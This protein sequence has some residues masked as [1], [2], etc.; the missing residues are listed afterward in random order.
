IVGSTPHIGPAKCDTIE[1]TTRNLFSNFKGAIQV[2]KAGVA[3]TVV[4]LVLLCVS[5]A[6][7]IFYS[8]SR[9]SKEK[10][11]MKQPSLKP[12]A[13]IKASL[14]NYMDIATI[15][16][17][18]IQ[19]AVFVFST[20]PDWL[21]DSYTN[22]LA[23]IALEFPISWY[24]WVL[25]G[26]VIVWNTY[27]IVIMSGGA[28]RL[29]HVPYGGLLL[30]PAATFLPSVGTIG[31][32]PALVVLLSP[33]SCRYSLSDAVMTEWCAMACW[34][35]VDW[36]HWIMAASGFCLVIIFA[37]LNIETAHIWQELHSNKEAKWDDAF[38]TIDY[39]SKFIMVML[40]VFFQSANL[41]VYYG[42]LFIMNLSMA[43]YLIK[44]QPSNVPW[45]P[46]IRAIGAFIGAWTAMCGLIF[47]EVASGT[48]KKNA[49]AG[50]FGGWLII[51]VLG[52]AI[53]RRIHPNKFIHERKSETALARLLKL[54]NTLRQVVSRTSMLSESQLRSRQLGS[55]R[56]IFL[57]KTFWT[58]LQKYRKNNP[59]DINYTMVEIAL[60]T[61]FAGKNSI[62]PPKYLVNAECS[63]NE[64]ALLELLQL[65]FGDA[66]VRMVKNELVPMRHS[67]ASHTK[68]TAS[69]PRRHSNLKVPDGYSTAQTPP[70]RSDAGMKV[71]RSVLFADGPAVEIV[72]SDENI[73]E[74]AVE[75]QIDDADSAA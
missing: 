55:Q 9:F 66:I 31:Y 27:A 71:A 32:V 75:S 5:L 38:Y 24:F 67:V 8:W 11:K 36:M 19:L 2:S 13:L 18:A 23:F 52:Y 37:P 50:C 68:S 60:G 12:K 62:D 3:F 7:A 10:A 45:M 74:G 54:F 56:S 22:I 43:A 53:S 44:T 58:T 47:L 72:A 57:E 39:S 41:Q 46:F 14:Y 6:I 42:L 33:L 63:G 34:S 70:S 59:D 30:L 51:V 26:L 40:R 69:G 21:D 1:Y 73:E 17:E 25:G 28:K 20:L 29:Q 65:P 15:F 64:D 61:V 16:I 49:A 48:V 35:T 4:A